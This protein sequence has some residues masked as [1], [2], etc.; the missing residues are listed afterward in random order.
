MLP[1]KF[2]L[3]DIVTMVMVTLLGVL[4]Y[5]A[6]NAILEKGMLKQAEIDRVLMQDFIVE[7]DA[8]RTELAEYKANYLNWRETSDRENAKLK[9]EN[10]RLLAESAER[11]AAANLR[12]KEK[13]RELKNKEHYLPRDVG[14]AIDLPVGFVRLYNETVSEV[15]GPTATGSSTGISES[16]RRTAGAPSGITLFDF[17]DTVGVNNI[18]C[19]ARGVII[20]EWQTWYTTNKALFDAA[21]AAKTS[22]EPPL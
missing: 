7:R 4:L 12:L 20:A 22:I 19:A 14:S 8:A 2:D 6:Y 16:Q 18:E 13:E 11:L 10:E 21:A 5:Q 17:A 1:F 9:T 15:F 3:R